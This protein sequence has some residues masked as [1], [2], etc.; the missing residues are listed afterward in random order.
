MQVIE[1]HPFQKEYLTAS[2][3]WLHLQGITEYY[4]AF[5]QFHFLSL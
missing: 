2:L 3:V 5:S 1:P 4:G